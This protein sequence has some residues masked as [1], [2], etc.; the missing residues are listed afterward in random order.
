MQ[1]ATGS[2]LVHRY[3]GGMK[4]LVL[5]IDDDP[6][7]AARVAAALDGVADVTWI[8]D[9][10][11]ALISLRRDDA[12]LPDVILLEMLLPDLDGW[13]VLDGLDGDPV[14][15]N[16]PVLI[17]TS[18]SSEIV[19]RVAHRKIRAVLIIDKRTL[20]DRTLRATVLAAIGA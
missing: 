18:I 3:N 2:R 5:V 20:N 14:L 9:G 4:A 1:H 17:V 12:R 15:E 19:R 8:A 10:M 11:S 16:I 13:G 6:E 7:I